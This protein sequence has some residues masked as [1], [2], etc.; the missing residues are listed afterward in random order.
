M[1]GKLRKRIL[2]KFLVIVM[3]ASLLLPFNGLGE[4]GSAYA[5]AQNGQTKSRVTGEKTQTKRA[6]S[7]KI[8]F[9]IT[10]GEELYNDTVKGETMSYKELEVPYFDLKLYGLENFYYN[11]NCYTGQQQEPGTPETAE[12]VVTIMHAFIYATEIYKMGI[13][14]NEAGKGKGAG[15]L[16]KY[17]T[18]SGSAGSTFMTTFWGHTFNLNYF[19]NWAFPLG[20]PGWGSTSDQIPLENGDVVSLHRIQDGGVM[21]SSFAYFVDPSADESNESRI[22]TTA[23]K[24]DKVKLKLYHTAGDYG[25]ETSYEVSQGYKVAISEANDFAK[26]NP[27]LH[28]KSWDWS[29]NLKTDENGEVTV[30]TSKLKLGTYFLAAEG[31]VIGSAECEAAVFKLKVNEGMDETSVELDHSR[32][33][34]KA[35]ETAYLKATVKPD[36]AADKTVTWESDNKSIATVDENGKITAVSAGAATITAKTANGKTATC[37][38]TVKSDK[39]NLPRGVIKTALA[40]YSKKTM[41]V[42]IKTARGVERY[43][44][45]YKVAGARK[46]SYKWADSK[47]NAV[48][49]K[50]KPGKLYQLMA[51]NYVKSN[52]KWRRGAWSKPRYRLIAAAR[53]VKMTPAKGKFIVSI[54]RVKTAS[55][56]Q[57]LYSTS[58]KMMKARIKTFNGSK[59][60]KLTVS[61]LKK[62]KTY[63][64]KVR[65]IKKVGKRTY[66]GITSRVKSVRVK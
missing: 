1:E 11:P 61:R 42:R 15:E 46:W 10:D 34:L 47:G 60:T 33:T 26:L 64:V 12:G 27:N 50:M 3:A 54:R 31:K 37:K 5:N 40:N 66:L 14:P 2:G 20:K 58:K 8:K 25:N 32:L 7:V 62:G 43:K 21:G 53:I 63:Y 9:N 48:I 17:I 22:G 56:Y 36:N 23:K 6:E 65:P 18:W 24:G 19:L 55:G 41:T 28:D 29:L 57:V 59:S 45:A 30:D 44:V 39:M 4:F 13:D 52:G 16:E 38:V 35:G 49:Q 51:A